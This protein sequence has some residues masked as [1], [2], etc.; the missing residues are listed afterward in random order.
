MT[1]REYCG[2]VAI[3]ISPLRGPTRAFAVLLAAAAID[4]AASAHSIPNKAH[5][6]P[7]KAPVVRIESGRV[8]GLEADGVV[9]F[10]GIPY[11]APP[12]GKLRWRAPQPAQHWDGVRDATRRNSARNAC[13]RRRKCRNRKL[14]SRSTSCGAPPRPRSCRSWFGFTVA[15]MCTDKLRFIPRATRWLSLASSSSA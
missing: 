6:T 10:K 11:A 7:A 12:V 13:K 4:G 9:S 1:S 3:L 14:A 15:R 8:R 2:R 5:A